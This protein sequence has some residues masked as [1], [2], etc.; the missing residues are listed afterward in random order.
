[1]I[2]RGLV[3]RIGEISG[4]H[5]Y[6]SENKEDK[7]VVRLSYF[8]I[9]ASRPKK[10]VRVGGSLDNIAKLEVVRLSKETIRPLNKTIIKGKKPTTRAI[11]YLKEIISRE[12]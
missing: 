9:L 11:K 1:M 3:A 12:G 10:R 5:Y 6:A 7:L 4:F 8:A 2:S